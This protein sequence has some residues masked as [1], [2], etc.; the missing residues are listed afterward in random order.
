MGSLREMLGI[1]K[2]LLLSKDLTVP[3]NAASG[4]NHGLEIRFRVEGLGFRACVFTRCYL[5]SSL[6]EHVV[7]RSQILGFPHARLKV[8]YLYSCQERDLNYK[9]HI[10]YTL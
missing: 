2:T 7:L 6:S 1:S 3:R 8:N 5:P 9:N 10:L 4:S